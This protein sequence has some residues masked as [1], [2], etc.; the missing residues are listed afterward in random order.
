MYL[1]ALKH[2]NFRVVYILMGLLFVIAWPL[3]KLLDCV[4]GE[5]HGT[6]FRRA[7]LKVLVDLH[8]PN[9][10][11][12]LNNHNPDEDDDEP[13]TVD[14]VL[15]IKVIVFKNRDTCTIISRFNVFDVT[16][17]IMYLIL[18]HLFTWYQYFSF[19]SKANI[20]LLHIWF[21]LLYSSEICFHNIF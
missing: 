3:S 14:E 8:G 17:C 11:A 15:I 9:S 6:F 5:D 4:L 12:N 10:Q 13:L 2:V 21:W 1:A 16:H 18:L 20:I 19:L 7:Q